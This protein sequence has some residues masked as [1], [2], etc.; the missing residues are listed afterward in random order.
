MNEEIQTQTVA[1]VTPVAPVEN[2]QAVAPETPVAPVETAP[3]AAAPA[4]GGNKSQAPEPIIVNGV[5]VRQYSVEDLPEE[6]VDEMDDDQAEK[7]IIGLSEEAI[8]LFNEK[9]GYIES[10]PISEEELKARQEARESL[11]LSFNSTSERKTEAAPAPAA[12]P[13]QPVKT[14]QTGSVIFGQ[15]Q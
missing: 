15:R 6:L 4:T 9:M 14:E 3:A 8:E 5:D 7:Y 12:A 2:T 10:M 1:P 11:T 13:A